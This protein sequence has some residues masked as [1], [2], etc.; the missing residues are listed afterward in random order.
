MQKQKN[1]PIL[2]QVVE[3]KLVITFKKR[4]TGEGDIKFEFKPDIVDA[5]TPEQC[6]ALNVANQIIQ[7]FGL[8]KPQESEKKGKENGSPIIH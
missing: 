8:D 4:D 6:A 3:Q 7:L 5:V 1:I 2:G